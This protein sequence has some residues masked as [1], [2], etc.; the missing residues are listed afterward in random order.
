MPKTIFGTTEKSNFILNMKDKTIERLPLICVKLLAILFLIGQA[1]PELIEVIAYIMGYGMGNAYGF[2]NT[3]FICLATVWVVG[4]ILLVILGARNRFVKKQHLPI[5]VL[6]L[7]GV[8]WLT[9]STINS[10]SPLESFNGM[11]GR[12]TGVLTIVSCMT[13]L[14]VMT[15]NNSESNLKSIVK[16]LVVASAVQCGWG[17]L[18]IFS[19]FIDTNISYYD[20]LNSISLYDICLPSGFTGSPLFYAEYLCLM[21]GIT[22]VLA[23]TE[24]SI[25]YTIMSVVY[26]YL[27]VDTHTITGVVGLGVII[28]AMAVF[29]V[30]KK[31][32]NALPIVLC[33]VMSGIA[34]A[35]SFI[36]NGSYTFYEGAIMWQDSFYRVGSTGYYWSESAEFDIHNALDVLSYT[37]KKT[38]DYIKLYPLV[39]TGA[40]CLIYAQLGTAESTSYILNG[41]DIVYNN[42]LQIAVTMGIPMLVVYLVTIVYCFVKVCKRLNDS[43][44]FKGI[45]ISLLAFSVMTIFSAN[46]ITVMPYLCIL[47][48]LAC[49]KSFANAVEDTTIE[50]TTDTTEE[51]EETP[52]EDVKN[53]E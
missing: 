16:T 50:T 15:F 29:M 39:G 31:Y 37:W 20:N 27:I 48:G 22:L 36:A 24:K 2:L 34:V 5:I 7:V 14:L 18:Q 3:P 41:F 30:A 52:S 19:R 40:D 9:V 45:F 11:Y 35:V 51:I 43:N 23:T 4:I 44:I 12:T 49:S 8:A 26:S 53:V 38:I 28:V 6:L 46:S 10:F 17:I 25:F 33:V 32:K 13:I 47:L 1:V 42:Y 21:L